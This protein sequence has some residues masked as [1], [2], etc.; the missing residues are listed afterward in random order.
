MRNFHRPTT[1]ASAASIPIG[2]VSR[3]HGGCTPSGALLTLG[4]V[5][6][7][8]ARS[9]QVGGMSRN[10][11][12]SSIARYFEGANAKEADRASSVF[13]EAAVVHDEGRDHVGRPAI[14][15]WVQDTI[16]RYATQFVIEKVSEP[17]GATTAVVV[18][19]CGTFP[20]SP[21]T[22]RFMFQLAEGLITHLD[23]KS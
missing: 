2:A 6:V 22:V 13:A 10:N 9:L 19:M 18:R 5:L 15:R 21:V 4:C 17:D 3:V 20:G 12:P 1:I 16:D 14:R 23:I 8:T 7:T 11:L